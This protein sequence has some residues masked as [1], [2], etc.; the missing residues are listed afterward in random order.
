MSTATFAIKTLAVNAYLKIKKTTVSSLR[1]RLKSK[2]YFLKFKYKQSFI[3]VLLKGVSHVF[4]KELPTSEAVRQ[5]Q[6][7]DTRTNMVLHFSSQDKIEEKEARKR[8]SD[9]KLNE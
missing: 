8:L 6:N 5:F 1:C 2:E 4:S 3:Q 7:F 9:Y